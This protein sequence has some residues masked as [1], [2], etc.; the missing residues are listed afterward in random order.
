MYP[1]H[2][3]RSAMN[4][5]L[6]C[7]ALLLLCLPIPL[8]SQVQ[9]KKSGLSPEYLEYLKNR[10]AG[11]TDEYTPQ[12][13]RLDYVPSPV[14]LHF[15]T[16]PENNALKSTQAFPARFDLRDSD[17]VTAVKD[18]GGGEF[19]GNCVAFATMGALES[20]WLQMDGVTWDLSEQNQA[21]CY[22]FKWAYGT[23]ATASM[24]AAYLTRFSGPVLESQDPYNLNDPTCHSGFNP[25]YY[26]PEVRW[27]PKDADLIKRL[28]MDYGA[29]PVSV[30]IQYSDY[31]DADHTYYYD[32]D[33]A[34]N[35]SFL[36]CGW[37]DDKVT[38]GG[39]GA[40]IIK[41]SWSDQ[42][43]ENGYVYVSYN[44]KQVLH[45]VTFYPYRWEND[46]V[47]QLYYYDELGVVY[48]L[49]WATTATNYDYA[50]G[51]IKFHTTANR[52]IDRIGTYV[53][54]QGAILDIEVYTGFDGKHL[55]GKIAEK[56]NIYVDYPGYHT[57]S[58]PFQ[59]SGDFYVK[60]RYYTPGNDAPVPVE[61]YQKADGEE[62][63]DPVL[64][65][66]V[67]WYGINDTTW[68][69]MDTLGEPANLCIR[70]YGRNLDKVSATVVSDKS[71]SCLNSDVTFSAVTTGEPDTYAWN[72]VDGAD[73]ATATGEGPHAVS[74]SSTGTKNVQ[75]IVSG[76]GGSD[77]TVFY[78]AVEIVDAITV[79][80]EQDT[81][82]TPSRL[83]VELKAYGADTYA[84]SPS[85][86]LDKTD[87][88]IVTLTTTETGTLEYTVTGTQGDCSAQKTVTVI[89]NP[90]P[91]ND[92][93]C[94][95]MFLEADGKT[96]TYTNVN[97]TV[98]VNEPAPESE[99]GSCETPLMWC[100]EAEGKLQHSVWFWFRGPETNL[101]SIDTRGLDDQIAV[102]RANTCEQILQGDAILVAAND[103]YYS[104][105][106]AAALEQVLT[107]QDSIYYIQVDGSFGGAEGD[108]DL[109]LW[110]YP[111]GIEEN[112]AGGDG[113]FIVY[114]NPGDGIF[115]LKV[116]DMTG[117]TLDVS[118]YNAAG[119]LVGGRS[120]QDAQPGA[121]CNFDLTPQPAGIYYMKVI[122]G[123][124]AFTRKL[125]KQ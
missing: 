60:V 72:F 77:T 93:V 110:Q 17:L 5:Q 19:G 20:D 21:A 39:T 29:L 119:Q 88:D 108:F 76:T 66:N 111:L 8:L 94:E 103:D 12:G 122:T 107:F 112:T 51:L 35:H 124:G 27:L 32:G 81:I 106:F 64:T 96:R 114:P 59:R 9:F 80:V 92:D 117:Q 37:D 11:Q 55:N 120:W 15:R 2:Q 54:T 30:H 10:K 16:V 115:T 85:D 38:D 43:G 53:L 52:L 42:W 40:W 74:Y 90:R 56:H 104:N 116:K 91:E 31:N 97:A 22:G 47:D 6:T 99:I 58:M 69:L 125:V 28:V 75:L 82:V 4:K 65:N 105:D 48:S 25:V 73:P 7:L 83:D 57:F 44:D 84:W 100:Y 41:N 102:Y 18:Q 67:C 45:D 36:L 62:W 33:E 71:V 34:P 70:A 13:Y 3:M 123:E 87:G 23:G 79:N 26:V 61:G 49:G 50:S 118:I 14:K 63:A 24:P 46:R 109:N 1:N 113:S 101:V 68:S 95:A 89:S 121:T 78:N 86:N 98:E